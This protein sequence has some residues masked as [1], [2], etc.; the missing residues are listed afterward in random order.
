[1]DNATLVLLG[2]YHGQANPDRIIMAD[3]DALIAMAVK[4]DK[5]HGST[6]WEE[7]DSD[8][9]DTVAQFY[10]D[11][12]SHNWNSIAMVDDD[13]H[14]KIKQEMG[15]YLSNDESDY[16]TVI[17]ELKNALKSRKKRE[18]H[19]DNLPT[20]EVWEKVQLKFTVREFCDLI[21][22]TN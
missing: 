13:P 11:T 12:K 22:L 6:D 10:N 16:D 19:I 14:Y 3:I 1:M 7:S 8:W 18:W 9:A 2:I 4:F 15:R 21:G 20:I 17:T 5:R